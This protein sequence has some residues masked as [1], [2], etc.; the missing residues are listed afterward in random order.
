MAGVVRATELELPPPTAANVYEKKT[1][2][3]SEHEME[4]RTALFCPQMILLRRRF[5]HDERG[6]EGFTLCFGLKKAERS[7]C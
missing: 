2:P 4:T 3:L 7:H 1:V 5:A 6:R